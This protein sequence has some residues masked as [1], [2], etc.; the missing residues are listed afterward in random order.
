MLAQNFKS[1]TD[2]GLTKKQHAAL[3]ATLGMLEREELPFLDREPLDGLSSGESSDLPSYFNMAQW[4]AGYPCGTV[5]CI[6][7]AAQAIGK[8]TRRE[9]P[10]AALRS[11]GLN[12]LFYAFSTPTSLDDITAS[13][14]AS[15]LR[16]YLTHGEPRWA[17]VLS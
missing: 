5:C 14:A 16:N 17:E 12:D 1:A 2:L 8:L 6:G 7:G 3:V 9:L 15:A 13:Q 10:D 11:E 4:S